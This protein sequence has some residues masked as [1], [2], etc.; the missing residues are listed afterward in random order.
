MVN[1]PI[2]ISPRQDATVIYGN[3]AVVW[4]STPRGMLE[5]ARREGLRVLGMAVAHNVVEGAK[6]NQAA[7]L[8]YEQI[9]RASC[10]ER[11]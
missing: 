7:Q 6:F 1:A 4:A 2:F 8:P 3:F 9:G 5:F 11:V 10:R